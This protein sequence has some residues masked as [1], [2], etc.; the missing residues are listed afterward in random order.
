MA[1]ALTLEDWRRRA[2][3]LALPRQAFIDGAFVDAA[4]GKTFDCINP[5]NGELLTRVAECEAE[6]VDR[7]VK[8]A[9]R[10]FESGVWRD[11]PPR[12]RKTIL[13]RFADL[14][15][16][17]AEEIALMET[18]DVGKPIADSTVIDG[19]GA[20]RCIRWYGEAI[21][22][23]YDE[24]APTAP[25]A[26]GMITRE[27]I[28]VVAAVVPWNF[29]IL[30]ASWKLG[31]ALA[32]GNSVILKPSEKSPLTA[33]RMAELAA[34]AGVPD[35]VFNVLPGFGAGAGKA[36]ARHLDVDCLAFTG[37]TLTGKQIMK[38]AAE[39]NLKRV[40]MELGGKTPNIVFADCP[41]L[42]AAARSAA[43][44]IFFNQGEMCT[45]GSR[46]LV[47]AAI[48]DEFLDRVM[49]TGE[50]MFPGDPLDP[51]TR[52][53]AIVDTQQLERVMGYIEAGRQEG[54]RVRM[55][56]ERVLTETGGYFV[57]PTIFDQ[58]NNQMKIAQEEIFGPVLSTIAFQT[59][60]EALEIANTTM[61]GLAAAAWTGNVSKAHRMARGLRAGTVWI[62]CFDEGD[63]TV[64][65]GG[66]KQSG[67]GRDK[68]LH[69]IDK[70]VEIKTTWMD[71]SR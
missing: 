66:F 5:A 53:G 25:D 61:Y 28:G 67:N 32:A 8:A 37:S 3:Q 33:L 18:L 45:A 41:D 6:D 23:L 60:E 35:G 69:A 54:A 43:F 48:K 51:A 29:P 1:Q 62:N 11:L 40:W 44:A 52:M 30:M 36:L 27:P 46:L 49:K 65:F 22:K 7:A 39:S 55:G 56:G 70:Y 21:D 59:E 24:I 34:E 42:D 16:R 50:T 19:P 20:A 14:L 12:E 13:V 4:S 2:A 17:H 15:D 10:A 58:V 26:L 64:P 9:R 63:L 71:L 31:P 68:S 38:D 57:A 47:E